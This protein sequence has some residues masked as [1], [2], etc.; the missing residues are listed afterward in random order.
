LTKLEDTLGMPATWRDA[1]QARTVQLRHG[2]L[3][4]ELARLYEHWEEAIELN[5]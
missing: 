1:V 3:T 4:K 5:S 2:E